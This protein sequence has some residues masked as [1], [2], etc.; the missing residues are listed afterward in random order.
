MKRITGK[1]YLATVFA[2]V[3][4]C[5]TA[6][7]KSAPDTNPGYYDST[8]PNVYWSP[9]VLTIVAC[10]AAGNDL[11]SPDMTGVSISFRGVTYEAQQAIK[12][13]MYG[14][15]VQQYPYTDIN[16][17]RHDY[18]LIFGEID[19]SA[20]MDEDLVL[21]WSDGSSDIIHYHCANHTG[22]FYPTCE[23]WW[24]LNGHVVP[25]PVLIT[26]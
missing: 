24:T 7:S 18:R 25:V 17:N 2:A 4:M 8:G 14:L 19:G 12:A 1:I 20:D 6:C 16:G 21:K 13:Q 15:F 3:A 5:V 22:G 10:D 11:I 26:K 9:V 23:R